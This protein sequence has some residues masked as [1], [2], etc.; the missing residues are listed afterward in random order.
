MKLNT[1]K[2]R[3]IAIGFARKHITAYGKNE[4]MLKKLGDKVAAL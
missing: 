3:H 2:Q 1:Q 4:S